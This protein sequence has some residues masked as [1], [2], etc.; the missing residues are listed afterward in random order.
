MRKERRQLITKSLGKALF[1]YFQIVVFLCSICLFVWA[2][3]HKDNVQLF[4][5]LGLLYIANLS[6]GIEKISKRFIFFLF[7]FACIFFLYGR[8]FIK[9]LTFE[10]WMG[11]YS[12]KSHHDTITIIY[13]SM[14]FLLFGAVFYDQFK[15]K[16]LH[17]P[18]NIIRNPFFESKEF[19]KNLQ[20]FSFLVYIV[21]SIF[22]LAVEIE[23]PIKLHGAAYADY[24][25]S[26]ES[27]LPGIVL[28]L[29]ALAKF[30]LCVFLATMPSKTWSFIAL[31][32]Y[33][34]SAVPVFIV[35]QRNKFISAALFVIC[36]YF[37]RDYADKSNLEKHKKWFGK[38]EKITIAIAL[39]FVFAFLSIY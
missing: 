4:F 35:G 14:L 15:D 13:V 12:F 30:V 19:I 22:M 27:S 29:S 1:R 36:Y 33:V 28:S 31:G 20:I 39:P 34:V 25:N 11:D 18:Q 37:L 21:L 5:S 9:I 10:N 32:I 26:F 2:Q 16:K 7:N 17:S 38:F 23:K 24:Y 8:T 3:I 6:Y